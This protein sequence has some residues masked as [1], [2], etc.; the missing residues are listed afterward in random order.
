MMAFRADGESM[1]KTD[2]LK[3]ALESRQPADAVPIWELEFHAWDAASGKHV[4]LGR[5]FEFLS[6]ARQ[7]TAL[8][9]NAQIMLEVCQELNFAALTAPGGFWEVGPGQPA[10]FWLPGEW[11]MRQL[12]VLAKQADGQVWLIASAGGIMGMPGWRNYEQFSY[13]LFDAPEEIDQT[14]AECLQG[15][16][17][18][19]RRLFN[20]GCKAVFS[21]SDMADNHGPFFNP[22]QMQRYI[23]PYMRQWAKAMRDMGGYSILHTDGQM[24]PI[25]DGI[26]DT[27]INAF[28]AVDPVAGMDMASAKKLAAGRLCLCG[29]V[30]CGTLLTG[31]PDDV[32]QETRTLLEGCKAGGG[33]VLGASNAVQPEVPIENYRAMI[34]AWREFGKY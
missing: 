33:L 13:K 17:A 6:P 23:L 12:E 18:N 16:I 7:N 5:E 28:Q 3:A 26:A 4:I 25:L 32:Y 30:N 11:R 24:T 29:N 10:Y 14:A 31:S 21:A 2:D 34:D 15:G 8:H 27:G 22:A 9:H 1:S 19:A 20:A